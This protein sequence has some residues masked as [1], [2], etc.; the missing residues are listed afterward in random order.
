M[1]QTDCITLAHG[2]GG[3]ASEELIQQ[4]FINAFG[5][6]N[7]TRFQE[8]LI[9]ETPIQETP[10][11]DSAVLD[12]SELSVPGS[13]MA[14]TTDSFVVSP[15]T[16]PGGDI[17]KL[18]V[19][20]T[21]NDLAVSGATPMYLSAG[22]ILEEGL[23]IAELKSIV[24]SMADT[25][26]Q[27]NVAIVTG[28]TKVV[29]RGQVDKIFIN[30]SG[31][32][33]IPPGIKVQSNLAKKG[34][35]ILINGFIGDHGAAI[36]LARQELGFDA[37]L[38]SDCAPLNALIAKVLKLCPQIKV[39]RDATRGGVGTVLSE[40]A[41]ASQVTIALDE[42]QLPIRPETQAICDLLGMDPLFFAN[43]GLAVFS[44]PEKHATAV[45]AVMQNEKFGQN[46]CQIGLVTNS[47]EDLFYINT[48]FGSKRMI[49]PPYGIQL[50]RIC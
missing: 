14:F 20:G 36:M 26:K 2:A 5:Q 50:P 46:A 35:V 28:D 18:A 21:V 11:Q 19:C 13:R 38:A 30:T 32:G 24:Q 4:V 12:M 48:T 3:R 41:K 29:S 10:L 33:V 9:Q 44:V 8:T 6:H 27:A 23:P 7:S 25:A 40:I 34:D 31:V 22:F 1:A 15:L 37:D 42:N 43:E 17:G 16:F 39:M 45:L 49:E 47:G